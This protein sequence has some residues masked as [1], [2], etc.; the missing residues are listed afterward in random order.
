MNLSRLNQAGVVALALV[1]SLFSLPSMAVVDYTSLTGA[2]DVAGVTTAILAA[3]G[4]MIAVIVAVWG[5]KKVIGFFSS[6]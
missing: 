3:A 6:R 4:L 5:A 2:I 1:A